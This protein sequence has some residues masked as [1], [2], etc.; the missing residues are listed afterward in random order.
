M[1]APSASRQNS[2]GEVVP[3][4]S[5]GY[6]ELKK[7]RSVARFASGASPVDPDR[8]TGLAECVEKYLATREQ[9][10]DPRTSVNIGSRSTGSR[11][12]L[13]RKTI[14]HIRDMNVDHLETFKTA[15]LPKTMRTTTRR[16]LSQKFAAFSAPRF[17]GDGSRNI[18]STR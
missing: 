6:T 7:S 2:I 12:Y 1:D 8:T 18:S 5:T 17:G 3:R 13:K 14:I 11:G 10:L 4:Q 16:R 15:G 9:E